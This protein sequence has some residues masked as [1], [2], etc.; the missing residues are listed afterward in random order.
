MG[1]ISCHLVPDLPV[2]LKTMEPIVL[3][4]IGDIS[5]TKTHL[6]T[7]RLPQSILCK[8]FPINCEEN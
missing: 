1:L 3:T 7:L 2:L 8:L 6:L 5:A 4:L